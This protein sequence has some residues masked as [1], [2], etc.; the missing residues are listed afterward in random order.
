MAVT[1]SREV[2]IEATPQQIMDVLLDLD[3]LPSWS[4]SHKKVEVIE[5]D[6]QGRPTKSK[7]IVKVAGISDEQELDYTVHDD[8]V[9]WTLAKS[10]QQRGQQGRYTFTP[11]GDATRVRFELTVDLAVPVPGFLVK[12]GAKGLMETATTGLREQVL[13]VCG[14]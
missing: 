6:E 11:D 14:A 13:K 7:Q 12:R 1:E 10:K 3:S 5:R 9:S 2:L 4:S 8:G